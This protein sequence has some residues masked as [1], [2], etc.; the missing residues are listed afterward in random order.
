MGTPI[1]RGKGSKGK[2]KGLWRQANRRRQP[3]TALHAGALPS[4]P[5]PPPARAKPTLYPTQR[6]VGQVGHT[7]RL[8]LDPP[9]AMLLSERDT[10]R[11]TC[12]RS[13]SCRP[14]KVIKTELE[15]IDH[16]SARLMALAGGVLQW[17][18]L[19]KSR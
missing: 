9:V 4:P 7:E 1:Y 6:L 11:K 14:M 15:S 10:R 12:K 5:P 19:Q 8:A 2:D 13:V 18:G 16:K 3:Q 17:W